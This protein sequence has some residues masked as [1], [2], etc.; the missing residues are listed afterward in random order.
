MI[1]IVAIV[2]VV[3]LVLP[4][5]SMEVDI[6]DLLG[7]ENVAGQAT[8]IKQGYLTNQPGTY[9]TWSISGSGADDYR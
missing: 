3:V 4:P 7:E 6:S 8:A 5:P 1:A 2:T 9:Y